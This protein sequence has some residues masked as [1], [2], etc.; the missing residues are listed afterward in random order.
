MFFFDD[1]YPDIDS[2]LYYEDAARHRR[3]WVAEN[4]D[5][6]RIKQMSTQHILNCIKMIDN[7]YYGSTRESVR[8]FLM[9]ELEKRPG[10]RFIIGQEGL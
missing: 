10:G 1:C 5:E 8:P 7:S 2:E 9:R 3:V 4:G 6:Y